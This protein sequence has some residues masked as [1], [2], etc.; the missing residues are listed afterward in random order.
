MDSSLDRNGFAKPNEAKSRA[1]KPQPC[2][3]RLHKLMIME[4][5]ALA[6][7]LNDSSYHR[8]GLIF[9]FLKDKDEETQIADSDERL[10]NRHIHWSSTSNILRSRSY[11]GELCC[12]V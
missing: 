5:P 11:H 3:L 9:P 7:W 12:S 10:T 4:S 8:L 6:R 2:F 1:G